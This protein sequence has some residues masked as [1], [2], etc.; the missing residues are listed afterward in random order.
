[1]RTEREEQI[2]CRPH[3]KAW[4]VQINLIWPGSG[5]ELSQAE[6]SLGYLLPWV[7]VECL[8]RTEAQ[9]GCKLLL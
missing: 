3:D 8:A 4:E 7:C 9:A 2:G 1:M 6:D 5:W